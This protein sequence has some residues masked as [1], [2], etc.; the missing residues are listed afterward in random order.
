M[1]ASNPFQIPSCIQATLERHRRERFR[2]MVVAATSA[3]AALLVALLIEGCMNEHSKA[4][5]LSQAIAC[6]R[7]LQPAAPLPAEPQLLPAA[8]P[9]RK[10]LPSTPP[11]SKGNVAVAV[12][13]PETVYVVKSGDT[14]TSI[15]KTHGTTLKALKSANGLAADRIVVG[16]RLKMPV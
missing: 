5:A 11:A 13:H 2:K 3:F 12:S 7:P 14:L 10:A 8:Q 6:N 9:H 4:S 1:N 15:A 16:T